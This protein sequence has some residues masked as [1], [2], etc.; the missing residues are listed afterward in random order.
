MAKERKKKN[1]QQPPT[2]I[3][4][5]I[6]SGMSA[7]EMQ[8]VIA[9]AIVEAEEIKEQNRQAQ[10]EEELKKGNGRDHPVIGDLDVL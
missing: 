4:V 2:P 8:H 3:N 10:K 6:P 7:E 5:A 9:M 1:P